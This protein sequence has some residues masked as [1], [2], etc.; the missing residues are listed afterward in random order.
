[1]SY[2]V[3]DKCIF[4]KSDLSNTYFNKN[5]HN[6]VGHY[7]VDLDYSI[8]DMVSIPFNIFTCDKCLTPQLKYL[9][10]PSEV[11]KHN[12][13]DSTGSIMNELHVK[14]CEFILKYNY[15]VQNIIEIGSSKGVLADLIL[16][17]RKLEYNIVE[18]SY[19][20]NPDGKNI[21]PDF[22]ENVDDSNINANTIIISH[23][24]EH[25]YK[26]LE[27]LEKIVNNNNIDNVFLVFP[28]LEYY[29]NNDI[30]HVLNT[31]HTYYIDNQFLINLFKSYGFTMCD[32]S[33]F[34]NHSVLFYF[35]RMLATVKPRVKLKNK[36]CDISRYF[37]GIKNIVSKFNNAID[38]KENGTNAYLWPAS[39]HSL[40]L[41]NFGLDF[42]LLS[43]LLDNS[44][45]KI[46]KKMY[47]TNIPILDFKKITDMKSKD[48]LILV[49]GGVFNSE[50]ESQ[51]D[52]C[53]FVL[54]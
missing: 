40:Y 19:F 43:G 21:I 2:I 7:Q 35:R 13:A 22:Y 50:V 15:D 27:I 34:K 32:R 11:Y 10:E 26:P 28:D 45:N 14:N 38:T 9:G 12:H 39:I 18:P 37:N 23:V 54:K 53:N 30:H 33:D 29:I 1:M 47:G 42:N 48:N 8:K 46:G 41:S 6:Y 4:C 17:K 16:S 36:N 51:L 31:E 25:F 49:N 3:R 52:G 5:L 20:G 24:F 44:P